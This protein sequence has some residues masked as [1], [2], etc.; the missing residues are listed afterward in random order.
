M[1]EKVLRRL[2]LTPG[3]AVPLRYIQRHIKGAVIENVK[4]RYKN[5]LNMHFTQFYSIYSNTHLAVSL[6]DLQ[7]T[8]VTHPGLP[9][10]ANSEVRGTR[11]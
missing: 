6:T 10:T 1:R 8:P 2:A 3:A 7:V 11:R 5:T 9:V 4:C